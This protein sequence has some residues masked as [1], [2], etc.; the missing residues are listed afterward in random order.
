MATGAVTSLTVTPAVQVPVFELASV[1]VKVTVFGLVLTSAHP[2]VLGVTASVNVQ[3]SNDTLST[4]AAVMVAPPLE[5]KS[6]V[7]FLHNAVGF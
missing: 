7:M 3:L 1:A 5:F 2:K 4:F 6:T